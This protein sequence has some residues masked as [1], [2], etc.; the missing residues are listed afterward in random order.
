L[1]NVIPMAM[2]CGCGVSQQQQRFRSA[3]LPPAPRSTFDLAATEPPAVISSVYVAEVPN[4]VARPPQLPA[5]N[6][7]YDL[8]IE[9]AQQHFQQGKK[10]YQNKDGQ[11]ARQEF[12][13]AIDLMLEASENPPDRQ[14]YDFKLEQ[15]VEA[16]HGYDLTGLG[17]AASLEEPQFEKA[18]LEDI[19]PMTFPVD[20]TL[21]VKVR[22]QV[23]ATVSQLPLTVNDAVLGYIH[24]FSGRGHNTLIAGLRRAGRYR[25]L[26]QRILDEEGV[27]Q[28]LIHLAQAES[29]FLPR[30]MSRKAA[31]GMWQFVAWRGREYGLYR[32]KYTDDRLDP[33]K[34]T[35]AAARHLRDLYQKFGDWH[36]AIAAYDCGPGVIERAVERTG[37]ADFFEMRNRRVLPLETTN[38][39]P[40]ILAM[41]IMSKNAAEYGLEGVGPEPPLEYDNVEITSPTHLALISDITNTPVPELQGLNPALLRGLAPAGYSLHVPKGRGSY[42]MAALQMVPEERRASWRLHKVEDGETLA[43][44]GKRYKTTAAVIAAANHMHSAAPAAGD[45]LLIPAA[46]HETTPVR[47]PA[48]SVKGRHTT[49]KKDGTTTHRRQTVA[50]KSRVNR[51][52]GFPQASGKVA[53]AGQ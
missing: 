16:I 36:L 1:L 53:S 45:Q 11:P 25:P 14:A 13:Q 8:L 43:A 40:I 38:Y 46:Y 15:M 17:S 51:A 5:T 9:K 42:L 22:E 49:A 7:R 52:A 2:A 10:Y 3:F 37:Y 30:A 32:T 48:K 6:S 19:L 12:D 50:S 4:V 31:G 34:S 28:E 44:I 24:Y 26:I 33:E 47:T 20:P 27:P 23:Q 39:V 35:R 29:G 18:P 21:K 41:T